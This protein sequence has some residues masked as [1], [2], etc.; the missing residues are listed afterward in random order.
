MRNTWFI[1]S[2]GLLETWLKRCGF[3]DVR[4]ADVSVTSPDEQRRTEW[5]F[6]ES[7]ADFLDPDDSTLTIEGHPAPRRATL[8]ARCP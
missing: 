5:M 4:I 2:T 1:P 7:L 8:I 6:F 3:R